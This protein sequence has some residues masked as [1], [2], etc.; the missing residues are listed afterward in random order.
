M[1][2]LYQDVNIANVVYYGKAG[3]YKPTREVSPSVN[4]LY[5]KILLFTVT[6]LLL[7]IFFQNEEIFIKLDKLDEQDRIIHA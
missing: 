4:F 3:I 6:D 2:K 5:N 1:F 7:S